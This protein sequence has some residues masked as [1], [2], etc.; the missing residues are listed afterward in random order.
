MAPKVSRIIRLIKWVDSIVHSRIW[1]SKCPAA[2]KQKLK[3]VQE[4]LELRKNLY[5][6]NICTL[7]Y[8]DQLVRTCAIHKTH[9]HTHIYIYIYAFEH[10]RVDPWITSNP[11]ASFLPRQRQ[12]RMGQAVWHVSG[13]WWWLDEV[14]FGDGIYL[15]PFAWK[16]GQVEILLQA[17][18]DELL[19]SDVLL[20][21]FLIPTCF[22]DTGPMRCLCRLQQRFQHP[23]HRFWMGSIPRSC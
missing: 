12:V 13:M 11:L 3:E 4:S 1:G 16:S 20:C 23:S 17:G 14:Q 19:G 6:C 7:W 10:D 5:V 18:F 9:T 8:G 15:R 2:I 22:F 21:F